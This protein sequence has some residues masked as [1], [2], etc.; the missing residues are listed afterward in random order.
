[1]R[2]SFWLGMAFLAL[3]SCNE[4]LIYSEYV[5]LNNG[6]WKK[7]DTVNFQLKDLDTLGKHN[8]FLNVRNDERYEFSNLF[9]ILELE[10]PDGN[11]KVDTLEYE[12]ALPSGEWLG[13]GT[14]SV[15]ES[16]LWYKE[17][18][19]FEES[20]VYKVNVLHAMRKNGEV[21]GLDDLVGITDVGIQIEKVQ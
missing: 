13:K 9:L 5:A 11:T 17:N 21:E 16:K 19:G 6:I 12:M 2:S 10:A 18:I 8:I 4:G 14:G 7:E 15:K 20:G 3:V 1:M